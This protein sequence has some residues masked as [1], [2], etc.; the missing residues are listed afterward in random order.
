MSTFLSNTHRTGWQFIGASTRER[1]DLAQIRE[2]LS[3]AWCFTLSCILIPAWMGILEGSGTILDGPPRIGNIMQVG[4]QYTCS[5]TIISC[6]LN[7]RTTFK[8]ADGYC[9]DLSVLDSWRQAATGGKFCSLH[10]SLSGNT[11]NEAR[12]T[13][14]SDV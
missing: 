6:K 14:R 5:C 9:L 8:S 2:E 10:K 12:C 4:F 3:L 1:W 7:K 11:Y 13:R